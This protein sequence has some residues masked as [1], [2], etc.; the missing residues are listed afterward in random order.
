[1]V[2]FTSDGCV[3]IGI[4]NPSTLLEVGGDA[5]VYGLI[6]RAKIGSMGHAD[7]AGFSHRDTGGTGNYGLL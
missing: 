2:R 3:G 5:D 1:M 4:T 7:Y 6:G